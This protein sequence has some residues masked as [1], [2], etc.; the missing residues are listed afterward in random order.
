MFVTSFIPLW[1]SI[2]VLDIWD[3]IKQSIAVWDTGKTFCFNIYSCF[4]TSMVQVISIIVVAIVV[5]ISI[6][7]INTFLKDRN[8]S[9]NNPKGK[10]IKARK[11]NKL[12]SEFLLA[13]I[14]PMIAFDFSDLQKIVLFII[15]FTVLAILCIRNNNIY[16]NILLEFKGYKM[17]TCDIECDVINRKHIYHDSLIISEDDLTLCEGN[18]ISYWDFDNYIYIRISE[19]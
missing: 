19:I 6:G 17:Y 2:L 12:S 11:A 14:L 5:F 4:E 9:H 3:F 10:I 8:A 18:E 16:T 7:G 15:Y 1:F 13:Y